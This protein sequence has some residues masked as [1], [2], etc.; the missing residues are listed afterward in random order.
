[1]G[2][3]ADNR[4]T[5]HELRRAVDRTIADLTAGLITLSA[6]GRSLDR[7]G[8]PFAVACRVCMPYRAAPLPPFTFATPRTS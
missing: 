7:A 1:M 5:R 4:R 3:F 2:R 8:C 6:A